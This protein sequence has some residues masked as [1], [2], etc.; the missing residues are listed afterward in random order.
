MSEVIVVIGA[1]SIGQSIARRVSA[2]KHV[3]LADL[4]TDTSATYQQWLTQL[5]PVATTVRKLDLDGWD[6]DLDG[7]TDLLGWCQKHLG[8]SATAVA[9]PQEVLTTR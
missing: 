4:S 1:G 3:V 6:A 7:G 9:E 2:G 8:R 5:S